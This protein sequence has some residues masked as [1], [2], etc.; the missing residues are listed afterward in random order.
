[1]ILVSSVRILYFTFDQCN[2][3]FLPLGF[4]L[5]Q[6]I[7]PNVHLPVSEYS[8]TKVYEICATKVAVARSKIRIIFPKK[9]VP[10][11]INSGGL[12]PC[13]MSFAICPSQAS[14]SK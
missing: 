4:S 13:S 14:I 7:N 2:A 12:M 10:N 9:C 6:P 3:Q 11:L 5:V 1:M 8:L